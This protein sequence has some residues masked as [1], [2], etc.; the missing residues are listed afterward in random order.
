MNLCFI[1]PSEMQ[2]PEIYGLARHLP[3]KYN[4]VILQPSNKIGASRDFY[5]QENIFVKYVPSLFM[6]FFHSE[7]TIPLFYPWLKDLLTLV[8][9]RKCDLIQVCD[10]EYLTSMPPLLV[11][12]INVP[13]LIVNDALIGIKGYS[14]GSP[15]VDWLSRVYTFTIGK[16]VLKRYDK[17]VVLY[18][19]LAEE[20]HRLGVPDEKVSVVPNGISLK[21]IDGYSNNVNISRIRRKYGLRDNER[22]I[23][24]VGR[25]VRVKRVHIVIEVIK[26]LLEDDYPIRALIVGDG[27]SRSELE[28][29][30]FSVRNNV[31]FTGFLY[32]KEKYDCYAIADLFMLPSF[33][34]GLPTVLLEAA[35]MRLPSIATNVNGIP[36]IVVHGKTGFLVDG[37]D[38]ASFAEYA[39]TLFKQEKLVRE[40]GEN[41]RE[42]VEEN[43]SWDIITKKY[44]EI[45]EDLAKR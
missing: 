11:K 33:S 10:Y 14:F 37:S 16:R 23:L 26:R 45:Y 21:E 15:I 4:I 8:K 18:S 3:K 31:I 20:V 2:R 32:G 7:I 34:E 5:L 30:A 38:I 19:K 29:S 17:V 39:A 40:M 6:S 36:D 42:H 24:Y 43:F 22:V 27:P 9:K 12:Q 41:A 28:K 25:L 44:V 1:N 13:I 35:A